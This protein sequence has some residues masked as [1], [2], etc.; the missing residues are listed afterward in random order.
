MGA[1]ISVASHR[2]TRGWKAHLIGTHTGAG[3]L[4]L[5]FKDP[6]PLTPGTGSWHIHLE[7]VPLLAFLN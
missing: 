3:P 7:N 6:G 5:W 1:K 4:C 2:I